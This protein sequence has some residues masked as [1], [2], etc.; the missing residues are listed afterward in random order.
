MSLF[1]RF[2]NA[3]GVVIALCK[4]FNI[5]IASADITNE[6]N[7]H[8]D[9]PSLLAISDI[10]TNFHIENEA[11]RADKDDLVNT[12]C[13]FIAHTNRDNDFVLVL[14]IN[15]GRVTLTDDKA[16]NYTMPLDRF[17][18]LFNGVVLTVVNVDHEKIAKEKP[19]QKSG[20][21]MLERIL[22]ATGIVFFILAVVFRLL[23]VAN[24]T[25][26]LILLMFIKLAG[27]FTA[28]MLLIQSLDA[29]NP[30]ISKFCNAAGEKFSC[31]KIL[32]SKAA[33]VFEGLSWS[34]VGFFYFSGTLLLL[35]ISPVSAA[36]QLLLLLN[37]ISLPFTIYSFYYQ[38]KI[39]R[40]WC[41]LCCV[42]QSLLIFEC[43]A[44]FTAFTFNPALLLTTGIGEW[45]AMLACLLLPATCWV[46]L[47]PLF[48]KLKQIEPLQQQLRKFKY[49]SELFNG[50]LHN[51]KQY[52]APA[53]DW[54]IVLGNKQ[55]E[56]VIT[57][58]T[59]PYCS[60]CIKV[61]NILD[62]WLDANADIQVRVVFTANNTDDDIKT[63][64]A[65]HLMALNQ[66]A[67]KK[68]IKNALHD[69]YAQKQKN[70]HTWAKAYPVT[71]DETQY[72]K[73]DEQ[74]QW[75]QIVGVNATPTLLINGYRLPKEYQVQDIK[76]LLAQL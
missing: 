8:P 36:R 48:I 32:T 34:E 4:Y 71:I 65:R 31:N 63:P 27:L 70:Y 52:P 58:V 73:I 62:E 21:K 64:V 11:Y 25:L 14:G 26:P 18:T 19:A 46:L 3:D 9:Y 51:Q 16:S 1:N 53:E 6:L 44:Q 2:P 10:L 57:M 23:S 56:H 37:L 40:N 17:K 67:N 54:S 24:L 7:I 41:L 28:A 68:T 30:F 39:A 50:L 69:W 61:H 35:I 60:P 43:I 20:A 49:N 33:K 75:C 5:S 38:G 29:D 15:N 12:P 74:S 66:L 47:R 76:Y 55:A 22:P 59:N 72:Y 45:S 42:V 13:P